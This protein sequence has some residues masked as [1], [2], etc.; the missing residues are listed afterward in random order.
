MQKQDS[1]PPTPTG[2]KRK[3]FFTRQ[4]SKLKASRSEPEPAPDPDADFER[5]VSAPQTSSV[6]F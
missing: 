6:A 5:Q 2:S 4:A 3:R 1:G